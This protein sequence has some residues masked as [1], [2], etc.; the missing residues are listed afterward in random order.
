MSAFYR[1]VSLTILALKRL[2]NHRL[3]MVCLWLGISFAVGITSAVPLFTDATQNRLLQ[4]ELTED[5]SNRPPFAFMWRYIGAWNGNIDKAGYDQVDTYLSQ[6]AADEMG[7]PAEE[8]VRHVASDKLRLFTAGADGSGDTPLIWTNI[9]FV[10]GLQDRIKLVEGDY[11]SQ[12]G[13]SAATE[14]IISQALAEQLGTQVG[15]QFVLFNSSSSE[16]Q[17]LVQVVGIWTPIDPEDGFWFYPPE[18]FDELLLTAE[19]QFWQNVAPQFETPVSTAVWYLILDGRRV[20]PNTVS[21]LLES[22]RTAET[23]A[24]A[25]L[26][27]TALEVSPVQALQSY[28][29]SAGL[30]NLNLLIFSLPIIGLVLYF[31]SLIAGLVIQQSQSEIAILHS[32]GQTRGQILLVYLIQGLFVSGAALAAGLTLG[33][34]LAEIMGQTTTFLDTGWVRDFD[35]TGIGIVLSPEAFRFGIVTAL[36]GL[37]ALLIP[38]LRSSRHTIISL[39]S[40]QSRN[41]QRPVW[42]RFYLDFM[43]LG[44]PLYGWYQLDQQGTIRTLSDG[45]D[46]FSNPLLFLVPVLFCFA[47]GLIG[48]RIFPWL[49]NQLA[50]LAALQ[51]ST[52]LLITLRRLGRAAGQYTGSML[53]LTLTLSLAIFSASMA[54]TLDNHLNDQVYYQVG[55]DLNLGELGENTKPPERPNNNRPGQQQE[56]KSEEEKEKEENEAKWLFLPVEEHLLVDGVENAARVGDY[57]ATAS[58]SGLQQ[59]GRILGIDR[60]DFAHVAYFRNDF[61]SNESLGGVLNRLAVGRNYILVN[62]AFM[63][64]NGLEVG[65]PLRLNVEAAGEFKDIDFV[66]AAPL[67]MFPTLYPQE[68]PFFV[69]HLD[70]LHEQLGGQYPYDVW[71]SLADRYESGEPVS[72]SAVVQGVRELGLLVVTADAANELILEEKL[73][74]ERQGLFGLLSVGFG[75]AALVT[76]LGFLVFA[77]VSFRQRLI[78]LGMLRAIGLSIGQM[79]GYL[80]IEQAAIIATGMLIGTGLGIWASVIFI[81]YFQIGAGKTAGVPPFVVQI[82]WDQIGS[83][84]LIFGGMFVIAVTVLIVLLG[85][86]KLF[87]AVKLGET[88]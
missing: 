82:A 85:R 15:E 50:R 80:A 6:Q 46:P 12:D 81:P 72:I 53:L 37:P 79:I 7:L 10:T 13:D 56:E 42:Q 49:L 77:I 63:Q 87:E 83:I 11:P 51:P 3:L 20:R 75:A 25:L 21:R 8:V 26:N 4:G 36:L 38:A 67:D 40:N 27:G 14:I 47:L 45:D 9:G 55:A 70:Y 73:R 33:R 31:V 41:Q 23:R 34:W 44:L 29:G 24:N 22:I 88:V 43:L 28:D 84:Y 65:D 59:Q 86:M 16:A 39:R 69:A 35:P 32:R 17:V 48:I 1:T 2:W 78:E 76:V 57:T 61:A 19:D 62:R 71:L 5:G 64:R 52:V 58:V 54:L 60:I 18:S 30:L 68:G 74:P 66:I